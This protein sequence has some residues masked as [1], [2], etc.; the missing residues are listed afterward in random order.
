MTTSQQS[1]QSSLQIGKKAFFSAIVI[2]LC[3]MIF[4]GILT[5]VVPSGEYQR[6]LV[7]GRE[8]VVPGSYT[9]VEVTPPPVWRWFTAPFEVLWGADSL[10]INTIILLLVLISGAFHI[11]ET[12]GIMQSI[13]GVLVERF[14]HRKYLLM[15]IIIF[16]FMFSAAVLGIYEGMVPMV[17]IVV[18][19]AYALGWDSLTGLGMSLL[20][21]AFGFSA[22][23]TNPF[24]IGVAQG[25]AGLPLFSGAWLRILFFITVYIIVYL[26]VRRHAM[27]VE[28]RPQA[29]LVYAE[30]L[31]VREN[32]AFAANVNDSALEGE[33]LQK[34]LWWVMSWIGFAIGFV[35][36]SSQIESISFL[37]FPV[38]GLLFFIAGVGGGFFAGLS[39][40]EIVTV[41]FKGTLSI[42]PAILLIMMAM[43][44][45]HIISLG[46]IMD[47]I[48]YHASEQIR[49]TGPYVAALLIYMLTMI[50]N[51]FVASAS[52][53]A[54][55]MMPILAPLADLVGLTRQTVV[56]AFDFGD[57][58]SNM[59]YPSNALL[60]IALG[61]TVV[62]YPK[63]LRW[64]LPIQGIVMGVTVLFLMIAVSIGFG[65][66]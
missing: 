37:A 22:A 44:V 11:L 3:L 13:L 36:V 7:D 43:S 23:V 64:T 12:G 29:S 17:V 30:D 2:L 58:F 27:K 9:A 35:L 63:W 34:S 57:G 41:F 25:I 19:L 47:T 6:A 31:E 54:F 61:F 21:M 24:T 51:F 18:P 53:K 33:Q 14:A 62:S 8:M 1:G 4:A 59:I 5:R 55:L 10:T 66:F 50:L 42:L 48:L 20:A 38:M 40:S 65:P 26:F 45:K 39:S 49:G 15:A 32:Y 56:L 60:L 28:Q 52:A 16:F 46:G